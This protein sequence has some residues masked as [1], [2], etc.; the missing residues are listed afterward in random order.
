[1]AGRHYF[2][3][4][5]QGLA[6]ADD[7]AR[8]HLLK[9]KIGDTLAAEIVKPREHRSIRR[10]WAMIKLVLDSTDQF[11][12]RYQL[13]TYLKI[14]AGHCTSI[15]N[16]LSGEVFLI[17]ESIDYATLNED[18]FNDVW[19]RIVDVICEEILPGVQEHELELEIQRV[20]GLAA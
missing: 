20:C 17:P 14:R 19:R 7:D 12:S 6:P 13:H 8:E 9:Y 18:Q 16:K 15:V 2:K 10:Y 4:T 11:K 3:R 5:L 1:M